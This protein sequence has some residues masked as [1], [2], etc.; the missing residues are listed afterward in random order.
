[1]QER[2]ADGT[3]LHFAVSEGNS[4]E[5]VQL[6]LDRGADVDARN[7]VRLLIKGEH[8]VRLRNCVL[9][10]EHGQPAL[11][12]IHTSTR[13]S[14]CMQFMLQGEVTAVPRAGTS[15]ASHHL[16]THCCCVFAYMRYRL[17]TA[18]V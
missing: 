14:A 1:M 6:L 18:I 4:V 13:K 8:D 15:R 16:T 10:Q 12:P 11:L 5:L 7:E 3:A 17:T 9:C 2:L